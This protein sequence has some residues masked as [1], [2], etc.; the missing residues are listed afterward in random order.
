MRLLI[1]RVKE[2]KCEIDNKIHSSISK[3][4]LVYCAFEKGDDSLKIDKAVKKISTLRIFTDEQDKLN[5]SIKDISGEVIVISSF[6]LFADMNTGN[7]PS[8]SRSLKYDESLPLY[9]DFINKMEKELHAKSGIFGADMK[10]YSINDG[11]VSVIYDLW[12][13]Y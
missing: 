1:Q 9:N 5:L 12:I 4:L 11:P 3:G 13:F 8:F 6:T 7:R 2:C 10:I